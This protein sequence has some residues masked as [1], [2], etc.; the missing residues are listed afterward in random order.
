MALTKETIKNVNKAARAAYRVTTGKTTK[1]LK[2]VD[3]DTWAEIYKTGLAMEQAVLERI[4]GLT[5]E[6]LTGSVAKTLSNAFFQANLFKDSDFIYFLCILPFHSNFLV[7]DKTT[8]KI[9]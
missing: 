2:D 3:D 4:E 6:A 5:G 7:K 9:I 1:G 8:I